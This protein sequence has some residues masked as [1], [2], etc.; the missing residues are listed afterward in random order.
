M[1]HNIAH[2]CDNI[3]HLCVRAECFYMELI[4]NERHQAIDDAVT[5]AGHYL[6]THTQ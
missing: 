3:A 5:H 1:C 6:G 2:L 4:K